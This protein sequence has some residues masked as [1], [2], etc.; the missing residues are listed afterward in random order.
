MKNNELIKK[1]I[2]KFNM[3]PLEDEGGYFSETYRSEETISKENLP[4]R[5]K[6]ERS[7][8]TTILYLITPDNFSTLH[9]VASDEMFHFYMGDKVIMLNL[10]EDGNG[11]EIK[12]GSNIFEEEQIQYLVPK[13]TWQ[14]AKLARGGKFAL[15]GTTVSPGFEYEDFVR[16]DAFKDKIL[17]KYPGY[18]SLINELIKI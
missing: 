9:K 10:F 15:L 5:Y 12:L 4:I 17:N 18:S 6:S 2:N 1:I 14:G 7:F 11:R 13:N 8:S 16:A 3:T